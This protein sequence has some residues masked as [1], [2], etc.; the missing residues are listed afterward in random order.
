M[1]STDSPNAGRNWWGW[2]NVEKYMHISPG[3]LKVVPLS[4]DQ[5]KLRPSRIDISEL[6]IEIAKICSHNKFE[7]LLHSRGRDFVD[8]VRNIHGIIDNPTDLV[9]FPET[10][11]Q[12]LTL[13]RYCS[14]H[15]IAC[16]PFG[17]GSS[18]ADG[19]SPPSHN[20]GYNGCIT[21]DMKN[22]NKIL[23]IDKKSMCARIQCGMYGPHLEEKL[24]EHGLTLRHFPQSFE[25][26]TLG[27]W[28]AT[29]GGGHFAT[30]LTHV[31]EM[32]E[33]VRIVSPQGITQTRRLPGS[34]AGPAEHRHYIG[35]EGCY[36]ILTEAWVRIRPRPKYRA[37]ATI[38]FPADNAIDSFLRGANAIRLVVQSGLQPSNLR[39]VDGPELYRTT[40][41]KATE[42]TA[43][44]LLGF[45]SASKVNLDPEMNM[46]LKIATEV[47]G[48]VQ[49]SNKLHWTRSRK[50]GERKGIA[51]K[52]GKSFMSG[53]YLFSEACVRGI[54]SNTFETSITW[55]KFEAFHKQ[56]MSSLQKEIVKQCGSGTVTCRLTHVY[57]D[58]PA[59]YYTIVA[60][61]ILQPKDRRVEQWKAIRK[62]ATKIMLEYGCTSTHH[63]AV[64]K[65]HRGHY[66]KERG[67][68][69]GPTLKAIK[70]VHD[71]KWIMNP[72]VL[73]KTPIK[74]KRSQ[75]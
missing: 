74:K 59:P 62:V 36:G 27:G 23:E 21:I 12:I 73:I 69:F 67:T 22:F 14:V 58:G 11:E 9:A 6:P 41:I 18:V 34:G 10:E 61:G 51:G 50:S 43:G 39:L 17:G 25:F 13:L 49:G 15:M 32:V 31:D 37:S 60:T 53:G 72:D 28:L 26:S 66:E 19:V 56:I 8:I 1:T 65:F 42:Q 46:A 20:H 5:I 52:W 33:S 44:I 7:R 57:P 38:L 3:S 55:D 48:V 71:P 35:S 54:L 40:Q 68:L 16:V 2:G 45:E 30:G 75:L 24:K 4:V 29:R 64:G 70:R 63:H 47:G